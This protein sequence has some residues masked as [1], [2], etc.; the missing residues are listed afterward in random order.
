MMKKNYD[1]L[2]KK[3]VQDEM[4]LLVVEDEKTLNK[5]VSKRLETAGYTVSSCFDGEEAINELKNDSFDAIVMDIMMPKVSGLEVLEEMKKMEISTPVLLLTA[6]DSIDDRVLG[7]D[8]GAQDYLVKPFA[9]D[10]LLAR[11]RVML[12]VKSSNSVSVLKLADLELDRLSHT[13]SRAGTIIP[14]SVKEFEIL[15][16]LLKHQGEVLARERIESDVWNTDYCG[17]SNVIDVYIRYLRKKIDD[18]FNVKL[19][20]TVRGVGYVLK[21]G[22]YD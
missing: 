12:R 15:E 2:Q 3:V 18:G 6:K 10:E 9:F 14:L 7:L 16:Y 21:E 13:V 4:K 22:A 11:I 1:I 20:H 8:M 19:I 5:I 17:M